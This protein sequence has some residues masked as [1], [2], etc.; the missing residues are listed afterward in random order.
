[1]PGNVVAFTGPMKA[2]DTLVAERPDQEIRQANT[3][4][5]EELRR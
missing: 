1:M 5:D 3:P 2:A 4:D